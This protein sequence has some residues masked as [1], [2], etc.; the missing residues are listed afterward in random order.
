MYLHQH[1]SVP[2]FFTSPSSSSS[3]RYQVFPLSA[4]PA[5]SSYSRS[6]LPTSSSLTEHSSQAAHSTNNFTRVLCVNFAGRLGNELFEYA[7]TLGLALTLKR[8]PVFLG[9]HQ[10]RFAL[11]TFSDTSDSSSRF[12]HRCK[13]SARAQEV[14]CCTFTERFTRLNSSQ[15]FTVGSCLQSYRYFQHHEAEIR[16]AV[17]FTDEVRN[18]SECVVRELRQ[19]HNASTLIGVHVRRG[20]MAHEHNKKMG[21]PQVSPDFL[22]RSMAFFRSRYPDC[23]FVVGSDSLQWCK[24]NVPSGY[25][26][27]YLTGHS[28]A[29]DM[30][31]LS[32]MDHTV[33]TFGT[34]SWWIG[35]LNAGTTV[36]MKDFIVNGTFL[37]RQFNPGGRDYVYPGWIPV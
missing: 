36:F 17:T 9:S 6:P 16:K 27:H 3:E 8:T 21:F 35:F 14:S 23:V 32:S 24:D 19:K 22:N 18:E 15:D 30:S 10:L 37:A 2:L 26:V 11:K 4:K 25:H 20:D 33:I 7:S 34:F 12:K 1:T 5:V 29:V 31:V 13:N 28:P